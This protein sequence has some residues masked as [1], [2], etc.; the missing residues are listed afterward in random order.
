MLRSVVEL[1]QAHWLWLPDLASADLQLRTY[2]FR[3]VQVASAV[4]FGL[5][6]LLRFG[7]SV[8]FLVL[9]VLAGFAGEPAI[10]DSATRRALEEALK[11][12]AEALGRSYLSVQNNVRWIE[13]V[14]RA[15]RAVLRCRA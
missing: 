3:L 12:P 8:P 6:A 13:Q 15:G 9:A 11:V 14:A 5:I 4:V 1:R 7:L 2:E 10:P